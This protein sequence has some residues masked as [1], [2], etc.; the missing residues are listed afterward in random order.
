M[1]SDEL[2]AGYRRRYQTARARDPVAYQLRANARNRVARAIA[3]GWG[4]GPCID[5]GAEKTE[6]HHPHGYGEW[7][8]AVMWLCRPCHRAAHVQQRRNQQAR[9]AEMSKN[10]D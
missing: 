5:C 4:R 7:A 8:L 2:R 6:A 3:A 10:A 1:T 9:D